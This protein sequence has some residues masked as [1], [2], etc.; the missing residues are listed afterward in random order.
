MK[1]AARYSAT[2]FSLHRT[3]VEWCAVFLPAVLLLAPIRNAVE[4]SMALQMLAEFPFVMASGF[5]ASRMVSRR[6][7]DGRAFEAIMHMGLVPLLGATLC[8]MFWMVPLGLDLARLDAG[9]DAAKLASLFIAGGAL[10]HGLRRAPGGGLVFFAGNLI[11]ML[12][13]VG[14]LFHDT[15][16]RLCASYLMDDQRLTGIGLVAYAIAVAIGIVLH[17]RRLPG[18]GFSFLAQDR[19]TDEQ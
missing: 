19:D 2:Q 14:L 18:F 1:L 4:S 9:I 5:A 10:Q 6:I 3:W 16:T 7:G 13:T 11:W 12:A 15:P 8:L 17:L